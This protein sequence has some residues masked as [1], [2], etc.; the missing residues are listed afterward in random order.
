[1][2]ETKTLW[3][4]TVE[5]TE[6]PGTKLKLL[7][8]ENEPTDDEITSA[9][10]GEVGNGE[11]PSAVLVVTGVLDVTWDLQFRGNLEQF[12]AAASDIEA[13]VILADV[14]HDIPS[15]AVPAHS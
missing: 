14:V 6:M 10:A 12:M 13:G 7:Y 8:Q 9:F 11:L 15:A 1:M 2:A 5:H 4:A 3:L